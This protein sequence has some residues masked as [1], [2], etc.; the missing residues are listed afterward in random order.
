MT[1]FDLAHDTTQSNIDLIYFQPP[2]E[3]GQEHK[4]LNC[5]S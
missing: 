5:L 1:P 3:L 4:K 2:Y